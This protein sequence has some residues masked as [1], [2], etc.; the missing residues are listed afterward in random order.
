M[1]DTIL[2]YFEKMYKDRHAFM[3][4]RGYIE[5]DVEYTDDIW[6]AFRDEWLSKVEI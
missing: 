6:N 1:I 2:K 3:V 4:E 5:K